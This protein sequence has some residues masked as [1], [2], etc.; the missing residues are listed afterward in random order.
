MKG[1][2]KYEVANGIQIPNLGERRFVGVTEDG[3]ARGMIAQICA[4]NKTLMSVSK[5]AR[6]GNRVVFDD[7]GSCIE[8]KG[9]GERIWMAQV[10]GMYP[11]EL[12]V[13]R[14]F[15]EILAA[16]ER[17]GRQ[18]SDEG[19]PRLML[20]KTSMTPNEK[21]K[22][23]GLSRDGETEEGARGEETENE[24]EGED[25]EGEGDLER[26]GRISVGRQSPKMPTE[27]E[28]EEHARNHC[29]YRKWCPHCV[30]PERETLR[31]GSA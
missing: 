27:A 29:P 30:K 20:V 21:G 25:D 18:S 2:V 6:A 9:T 14:K 28:K 19:R 8:D 15:G 16:R 12:C 5:I 1:G 4:V 11:V 31:A 17:A 24:E 10:G 13:P 26:E 7:D 23:E 22:M 3:I